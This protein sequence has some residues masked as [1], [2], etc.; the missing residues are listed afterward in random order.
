MND[1]D[2]AMAMSRN[3]NH[4]VL[5]YASKFLKSFQEQV[6]DH[7]DGWSYWQ[8]PVRAASKLMTLVQSSDGSE[9]QLSQ[10]LAVIKSFYTRKG[11]SAGMEFPEV[12]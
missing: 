5:G 10:A 12:V 3:A 7:S 9:L 4:P 2:I 6:N 8:A 1:T 11:Y